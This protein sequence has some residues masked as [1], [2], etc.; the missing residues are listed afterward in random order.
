MEL[1]TSNEK[2]FSAS[3]AVHDYLSLF[4]YGVSVGRLVLKRIAT[5]LF[6]Q[7]GFYREWPEWLLSREYILD[8]SAGINP[9]EVLS[10][11]SHRQA[12]P[13]AI[14]AYPTD[15]REKPLGDDIEDYFIYHRWG[16]LLDAQISKKLSV[17]EISDKIVSRIKTKADKKDPS[18]ETYS[19][20][21][22]VVNLITWMSL[23]PEQEY[24]T[25]AQREI[26][27]FLM[28]S[29]K[30]IIRNLE[31]YGPSKT[32]NHI[33]NDARALVAVGSVFDWSPVMETGLR[34]LKT[35]LPKLIQTEG[36]LRERSSHY[37]LIILN[38]MLDAQYF[39]QNKPGYKQDIRLLEYFISQMLPAAAVLCDEK[40][41]L[42]TCIGDISPD[43]TTAQTSER[44]AL[45]YPEYWP[46]KKEINPLVKNKDDW[47]WL[48][49]GDNLIVANFPSG[50]FPFPFPTHGHNDL[51]SFV[52]IHNGKE[53]LC[54]S[55]RYRYTSDE[56]S[57]HQKSALGHSLPLVDGLAPI[58]DGL[59][60]S[61]WIPL[62]Y[63]RAKLE[64]A[65]KNNNTLY[66]AHDG[67][68]RGGKVKKHFREISLS[69]D[70]IYVVDNFEGKQ[71]VD[72]CLRWN[73]APGLIPSSNDPFTVE[74]NSVKINITTDEKPH[75]IKWDDAWFSPEYGQV[76]KNAVFS[77]CWKVKLPFKIKTAFR[78]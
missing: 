76:K 24:K 38:W 46:Y 67:F 28:D 49:A 40:G 12:L 59:T 77:L 1:K 75:Q 64:A 9:D 2:E 78:I 61:G 5:P 47:Y 6:W 15:F 74:G 26:G 57:S 4:R 52:W 32:N 54:D 37:Q 20:C 23:L 7:S 45:L 18:W 34:I 60:K 25:L 43:A 39:L 44:L 58:S 53:L 55:G 69:D 14:G 48:K 13:H 19:T 71:E 16:W 68:K 66:F 33:L 21:E 10:R 51:T 63:G 36:F 3:R 70:I 56:M 30:W 35:M 11:I 29:A 72:I 17:R 31:Y 42:L 27:L 73:F 22:R 62:P 65:V 50:I 8:T 41:C